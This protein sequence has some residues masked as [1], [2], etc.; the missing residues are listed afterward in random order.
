MNSTLL[1]RLDYLRGIKIG[2]IYELKDFAFFMK[3][4]IYELHVEEAPENEDL[5]LCFQYSKNGWQLLNKSS[6]VHCAVNEITLTSNH[7]FQLHDGDTLEWGLSIWQINPE[8]QTDTKPDKKTVEKLKRFPIIRQ[9][10]IAVVTSREKKRKKKK[11][12]KFGNQ[13]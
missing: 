9:L 7:W 6:E 13:L 8:E 12:C 11:R 10:N 3:N 5:A 4:A 2:E 1:L